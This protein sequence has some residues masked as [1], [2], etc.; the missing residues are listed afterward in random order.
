M[1]IKDSEA[2]KGSAPP[3]EEE[4]GPQKIGNLPITI[5]AQYIRDLSFENPHAP[6]SLRGPAGQPEMS[7]DIGMDAR[8]IKDEKIADL[9]EVA[10]N[11]RATAKSGEKTLFIAEVQYGVVASLDNVPEDQHHPLLL[12]EVPRMAFPFVRQ[13]LADLTTQ[14]GYPPLFLTPIDFHAMYVERFKKEIA[15]GEEEAKTA[16]KN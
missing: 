4:D 8:T 1:D 10:L 12:I 14:G 7:V 13:I 5:H 2:F 11:I 16:T 15:A 3:P 6:E 9:Y